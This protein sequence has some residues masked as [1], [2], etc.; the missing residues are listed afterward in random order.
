MIKID[1]LPKIKGIYRQNARIVNWFNVGGNAEILFKPSDCQDLEFFLSHVNKEIPV[2]ILGV[3]S[4]V[5]ISDDG[6]KGVLIKLGSE[7][8]K[9]NHREIFDQILI[10]CGASALCVNVANYARNFG[11]S[12]LEF[13][14]GIPGSIG[15]AIAMNAGCYGS[16]I[17]NV[18]QDAKGI[19]YDGKT[20]II[21]NKDFNF[22]YRTNSLEKKYFFV[23]GNFLVTKSSVEQVSLTM[24]DLQNKRE[25]F[26]PIKA[27]TGGST[28]KN[29]NSHKAWELI[30]GIGFR[31]KKIGDAQ[32]STKHCNFLINTGNAS[33]KDL[34]ELANQ[35]IFEVKKKYGIILE[36]EIKFIK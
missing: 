8:S 9:I 1:D 28:F 20:K 10:N 30:D 24:R 18:L 27:K 4:N 26:Q 16:E 12:G 11:L 21:S 17:S 2:Q 5:I 34:I 31:G 25:E 14:S 29:P 15:G 23:E 6:V 19:D 33:A 7:F 22:S 35:A 3:A 13:L 36:L 32:F